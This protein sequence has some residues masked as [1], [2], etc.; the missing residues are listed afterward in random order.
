MD[1]PSVTRRSPRRTPRPARP[2]WW[3]A[4]GVLLLMAALTVG[5]PLIDRSLDDGESVRDGALLV[6]GPGDDVAALRVVGAGWVLSKSVSNP[7]SQYAL[8]RD[9]V[10]LVAGFVDL[11]GTADAGQLWTGLRK[12]QSVA[13]SGSRLGSARPVTGTAGAKGL[14]GALSRDGRTGTADVWLPPVGSYAVEVT[15]LAEPGTG[16]R[17]LAD[18]MAVARSVSFPPAAS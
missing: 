1:S 11:P 7:N 16:P 13:D 3:A 17:A 2:T 8:S 15:V 5:W 10:D 9:G 4:G 6:L 14:T 12:V 18:A